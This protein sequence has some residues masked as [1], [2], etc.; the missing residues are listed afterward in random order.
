MENLYGL[1]QIYTA[2]SNIMN[3]QR[4]ESG[5]DRT[6]QTSSDSVSGGAVQRSG[7]SCDDD[8]K[9]NCEKYE[10]SFRTTQSGNRRM[11]GS[12]NN[13]IKITSLA[14]EI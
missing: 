3:K 13:E 1:R 4:N 7:E 9:Q 14:K 5:F 8:W 12:G 10:Y 2:E 6:V 11:D